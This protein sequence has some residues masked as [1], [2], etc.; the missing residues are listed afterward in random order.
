V[1]LKYDRLSRRLFLQGLGTTGTYIALGL[2]LL[3]SLLPS[4][5]AA[6]ATIIPPRFIGMSSQNGVPLSTDWFPTAR[7]TAAELP[8]FPATGSGYYAALPHSAW[9]GPVVT[10]ATTGISYY[11]DQKFHTYASRMNFLRGLD[12]AYTPNGNHVGGPLLGN[13]LHSTANLSGFVNPYPTIDQIMAYTSGFYPNDG[14]G[15]V[16]SLVLNP[17]NGQSMSWGFA[18]PIQKSGG[19]VQLPAIY[20]PK[21]MFTK[22]FGSGG[23]VDPS[24]TTPFVDAVLAGFNRVRNGRAISNEDKHML[25]A[26]FD[27]FSDLEKNLNATPPV[28]SASCSSPVAPES[29]IALEQSA[30]EVDIKKSY[31]LM[32]DMLVLGMKCQRTRVASYYIQ[33]IP[34]FEGAGGSS[35][36]Q[37]KWHYASH[38]TTSTNPDEMV[39]GKTACR[40]IYKWISDNILFDLVNK[41]DSIVEANGKTMLDNSLLQY[42][43]AAMDEAH[44]HSSMPV[45]LFGSAGGA[46]KTGLYCDYQN[47][48]ETGAWKTGILFNQYL[49]TAMQAVGLT[50]DDYSMTALG[51]LYGRYPVGAP[52]YGEY[53]M[54]TND[55]YQVPKVQFRYAG[56]RAAAGNKLP[57]IA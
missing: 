14:V 15:Y 18:N 2:P 55:V 39:A 12:Y 27:L 13:I 42:S 20:D 4:E 40:S 41:L 51:L 25:D 33:T 57:F 21:A 43:A 1:S 30:S 3:P 24:K 16:R 19:I 26:H 53:A 45:L 56:A 47:R 35:F 22:L 10:N 32:N 8:M 44:S 11:F 36:E 46:L 38:A 17:S 52:G 28:V 37:S 50:P 9:S 7:P 5:A 48:L 29:R 31:Q 23:A 49:A 34:G 54:Q 6:S